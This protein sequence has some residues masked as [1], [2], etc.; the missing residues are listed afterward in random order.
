[1]TTAGILLASGASRRFGAADKL[2]APFRGRPLVTHAAEALAEAVAGPLIVVAARAEVAAALPG[3]AHV[4]PGPP[5]PAQSDSLAAGIAQARA[6]G[7]GRAVV[8]LGDMPRVTP[9]L[10]RA[11]LARCSGGQASAATDG[12]RPMPPACFPAALFDRLEALSGDRGAA[13][14]LRALPE[15]QLVAAPTG[16]LVDIDT[17]ADLARLAGAPG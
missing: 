3:F 6:L 1:M 15:A 10:I 2:L 7:A 9:E 13:P 12:T 11:V 4:R 8:V 17:A 5:E 16:A 14:V